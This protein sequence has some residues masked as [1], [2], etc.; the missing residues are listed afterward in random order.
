MELYKRAF[1]EDGLMGIIFLASGLILQFNGI[2]PDV[3]CFIVWY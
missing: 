3:I 1:F 2:M